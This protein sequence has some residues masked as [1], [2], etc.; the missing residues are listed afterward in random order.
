LFGFQDGAFV[1]GFGSGDKVPALLEPGEF[2]FN[3]NAVSAIGHDTLSAINKQYPR[4]QL[5]CQSKCD[6]DP[7]AVYF[8]CYDK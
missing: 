3:R 7:G 5:L 4:F 2:V 8:V 1:P 6:C